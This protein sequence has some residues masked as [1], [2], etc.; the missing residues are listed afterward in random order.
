MTEYLCPIQIQIPSNGTIDSGQK[1][2]QRR[3]RKKKRAKRAQKSNLHG[4]QV[5]D[6]IECTYHIHKF[7][8]GRTKKKYAPHAIRAIRAIKMF[9]YFKMGT[10][11]VKL[12]SEVNKKV[13]KKGRKA[14]QER[15]R[16]RFSRRIETRECPNKGKRYTYVSHVP[17]ESFSGLQDVVIEDADDPVEAEN[18]ASE[19]ISEMVEKDAEMDAQDDAEMEALEGFRPNNR[20]PEQREDPKPDVQES[21]KVQEDAQIVQEGAPTGS[22]NAP[23]DISED[24]AKD[25][26]ETKSMTDS[27]GQPEEETVP[28]NGSWRLSGRVYD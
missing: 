1:R 22:N 24:C 20:S 4:F 6:T 9:I 7:I 2:V 26:F 15:I 8:R 25:D 28:G 16:L 12:D 19:D 13:W 27:R 23:M 17:V 21:S 11:I 10:K 5:A 3:A 18:A 14:I